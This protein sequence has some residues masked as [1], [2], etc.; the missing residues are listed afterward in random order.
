FIAIVTTLI[1]MSPLITRVSRNIW[2]NLFLSFD[3]NKV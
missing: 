3:K 1:V 2:I